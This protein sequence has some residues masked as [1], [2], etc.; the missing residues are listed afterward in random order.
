MPDAHAKLSP[1]SAGRWINCPGSI[2][3][4][5][6]SQIEEKTS[7]YAEEGTRAHA[8][9]EKKL[10]HFMGKIKR[11]PA[12]CSDAEMEEATS[13]YADRVIEIFNAS[14]KGA[15]LKIEQQFSLDEWVPESFG[16]SDAVILSDDALEVIDLKYGKGIRVSA[17]NNPQLRLYGLGAL[18]QYQDLFNIKK[19]RMTIIQP[20]LDHISTEELKVNEL[21]KWADENVVPAAQE[22]F[23]GIGEIK[24]GEWC[25]FC[26]VNATCRRRAEENLELAKMEFRDADLLSSEEIGEVLEKAD[27]L[28]KWVKDIQAYALK[29]ALNGE[30]FEGWKLVEGRSNRIITDQIKAAKK[31]KAAGFD[32]AVLYKHELYGIT[33]LEKNCGKKKLTEVLGDLIDKPQG[34]PV[35]VPESDKREELNSAKKDF[36][37]D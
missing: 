35:L 21:R 25:R 27:E 7:E 34:K 11:K 23:N 15:Q 10:K 6:A 32:E 36:K 5:E 22:A 30:K 12:K 16:T 37:E 2:A 8:L 26:P 13:F 29:E 17:V 28:Q 31:L 3:L 33:Q 20:R 19:V 18:R 9:A 14:G 24:P 4:T 1:S